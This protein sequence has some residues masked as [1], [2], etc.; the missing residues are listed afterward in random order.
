LTNRRNAEQQYLSNLAAV[1]AANQG[2]DANR[3]QA[4]ATVYSNLSAAQQAALNRQQ[5]ANQAAAQL[6]YY[7]DLL[8][9]KTIPTTVPTTNSNSNSNNTTSQVI[10]PF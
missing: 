7:R 2:I 6:Q 1:N 5:Q 4:N 10:P 8:K 3:Q 9:N